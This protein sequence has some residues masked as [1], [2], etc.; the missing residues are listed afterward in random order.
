MKIYG[1][2]PAELKGIVNPQQFYDLNKVSGLICQTIVENDVRY[3]NEKEVMNCLGLRAPIGS[4]LRFPYLEEIG[5]Y[6]QEVF[7]IRLDVPLTGKD[8]KKKRYMRPRN[9]RVMPYI[10]KR[11]FEIIDDANIPLFFVEGEKKALALT[12]NE[13]FA[14]GFSGVWG[15]L[16]QKR[17]ARELKRIKF[18]GRKAFICY[19]GDK[20][21]NPQVLL[22]QDRLAQTLV[23]LGAEVYVI[24]MP[25]GEK[26]DEFVVKND[27]KAFDELV[28]NA[29]KFEF[30]RIPEIVLPKNDLVYFSQKALESIAKANSQ[31]PFIFLQGN[32]P[33]RVELGPEGRPL[34]TP[35][36]EYR[37]RYHLCRL[38]AW[39][40][41]DKFG[42]L[43]LAIPSLNHIRDLL[44]TPQLEFPLL[45]GICQG[46]LFTK[47]GI[48]EIQQG[49]SRRSG[50][51]HCYPDLLQ[52]VPVS[53]S[54]S[55]Q[56]V[57][58]AKQF[59]L[60]NL[61]VDFPFISHSDLAHAFLL[62]MLPFIREMIKGPCPLFL[63]EKSTPG[64]GATLLVQSIATICTG[65]HNYS[66]LTESHNEEEFRKR[67]T[68][69]LRNYPQIVVI[70]N[71][72]KEL[73]SGLLASLLTETQW[74]D[75]LLGKSEHIQILVR[76]IFI[77]TANNP[78]LSDEITRRSIRLRMDARMENPHL[79][80]PNTFKHPNLL[81]WVSKNRAQLIWAICTIVQFWISRGMPRSKK[82]LGMFEDW[83]AKGGGL[84]E[85]V[86]VDGFLENLKDFYSEVNSEKENLK[87]FV[88]FWY[89]LYKTDEVMTG[90]LYDLI[91]DNEEIDIDL[92]PS[93]NERSQRTR[94]GFFL[95]RL[96]DRTFEIRHKELLLTLKVRKAGRAINHTTA[97]F[98]EVCDTGV[99][100]SDQKMVEKIKT[101]KVKVKGRSGGSGG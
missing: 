14:I 13:R 10:P 6:S 94:F 3:V 91:Q 70:D 8:G 64:T 69:V 7:N 88:Y 25:V 85:T 40:A 9:V 17:P 27:I 101:I 51:Y 19:D 68:S 67:V 31:A 16:N 37:L 46:P 5:K 83:S 28:K 43:T 96:K 39:M 47:D 79:R 52:I 15:F 100:S 99:A 57:E 78:Q 12:Q 11:T 71:L 21:L 53:Q 73:R 4:G 30:E 81:E 90:N 86:K 22:A 58:K 75:R 92:G 97:Y 55:W 34:V 32:Q 50:L 54:P 65:T 23:E 24:D 42:E 2:V 60:E 89:D 82:S 1:S 76:A 26:P 45:N 62:L 63:I 95:S 80:N 44:A 66:S 98:L 18:K 72:S 59:I 20:T 41:Y 87:A 29:K 93:T 77:A 74:G 36:D 61:F 56:E 84:L 49:Y 33:V 38:T 35:L 48:L